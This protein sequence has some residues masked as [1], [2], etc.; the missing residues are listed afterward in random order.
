MYWMKNPI[1]RTERYMPTISHS[2]PV[3]CWESLVATIGSRPN[4]SPS[5]VTN[6]PVPPDSPSFWTV[7]ESGPS[8]ASLTSKGPSSESIVL[9][10]IS[11]TDASTRLLYGRRYPNN[12]RA[13][14]R[15]KGRSINSSTWKSSASSGFFL[16]SDSE[17]LR[18]VIRD[19]PVRSRPSVCAT[20]C[21][22]GPSSVSATR[23]HHAR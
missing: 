9:R 7:I 15:L 12:L 23:D 20:S 5:A 10:T 1:T 14:R 21:G 4:R 8:I 22:I 6:D 11:T 13:R 18:E 2:H 3:R 17:R 19:P 16:A